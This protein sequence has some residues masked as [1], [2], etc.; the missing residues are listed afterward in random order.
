[1]RI[2][3]FGSSHGY[4]EQN[5]RC[6]CSLVE[7]GGKRYFIDMGTNAAECLATRRIPIEAID[8]V[9]VTHMHGDH[10]NGL[11]SFIDVCSWKFKTAK[12]KFYLP[13]N[14]EEAKTAIN[15]WIS[16]NGVTL[17]QDLEFFEV[18]EGEV[19]DDGNLKVTAFK[20]KHNK[21]SYSYLLETEGKRVLFSGD[22]CTT[23][24][25][26]ADFPVSVLDKPLDLAICE[27]SHFKATDYLHLFKGNENLKQ[28][29]FN[30]YSDRFIESVVEMTRLLPD[31]PVFRVYDDSEI[32][33]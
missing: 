3:F 19:F 14:P 5:R 22:L 25:P 20:T 11:I 21:N 9:F 23:E 8:S 32:V 1:M 17:R 33:L 13:V 7:A 15:N 12:P 4:P 18:T 16:L 31:I 24:G 2:V 30:H 10:S 27:A 26:T 6:S 29:C 28:L